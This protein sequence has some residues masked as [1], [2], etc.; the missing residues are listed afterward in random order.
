M[1]ECD[2]RNSHKSSKLHIIYI[3][4]NTIDTLLL[5]PSLHFNPRHYTCRHFTSSRSNFIQ[6][7]FTT[8]HY[9]LI[10]LNSIQI[11]YRSISPHITTLRLKSL[12]C[13]FRRFSPHFY[14]FHFTPFIVAF[15]ILFSK[16]FRESP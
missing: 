6:L 15:L 14:S 9:P 10:W 13:T 7:H 3:S 5:T 16:N 8:L 11:S 4:S 12:Y 2:K 1:K